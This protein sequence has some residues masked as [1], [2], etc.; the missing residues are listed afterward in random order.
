LAS[1]THHAPAGQKPAVEL[2]SVV[3]TYATP[4]GPVTVLKGLDLRIEPAEFVAI[5]GKS[6]SGKSSLLNMITGIDRPTSGE[7]W[8]ANTPVH[9]LREGQM[10][11]WRGRHLGIVF[12]FFQLL[13]T[14]T[15]LEN[16]MLP[17][18]FCRIGSRGER[19]KRAA[20]LLDQMG[21]VPHADKLPAA[22][23]G[24]QQQRVAIA[25][26]LATDPPVIVADEPT[27]NL[28]SVMAASVFRH[29]EELAALGKTII[30]VTHDDELAQRAQR[31]VVIADGQIAPSELP[32]TRQAEASALPH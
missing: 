28:D 24:G 1:G 21:L 19:R 7:V 18:E 11:G 9:Q 5:V 13:P 27:G 23:S 14:L 8:V 4:A 3:K 2:R 15:L 20:H 6:G 17:M 32:A 12:Q 30:M 25:R 10:A 16:V 31:L 26:A 29:F 22:I